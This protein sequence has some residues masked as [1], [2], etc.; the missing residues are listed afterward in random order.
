M[1]DRRTQL[2]EFQK[3]FLEAAD[4]HPQVE[5]AVCLFRFDLGPDWEGFLNSRLYPGC[6][7]AFYS[8]ARATDNKTGF[9]EV[10]A[11]C[12][13]GAPEALAEYRQLAEGLARIIPPNHFPSET[14]HKFVTARPAFDRR[15][16]Q[17]LIRWLYHHLPHLHCQEDWGGHPA[18]ML[19]TGLFRA[20]AEAIDRYLLAEDIPRGVES[21]IGGDTKNVVENADVLTATSDEP[22]SVTPAT[23]ESA[24]NQPQP[25]N[26]PT[27]RGDKRSR[28]SP[29]NWAVAD[30]G[31][32]WNLYHLS[33]GQW[34]RGRKLDIP[35]GTLTELL[36]M[37]AAQDGSLNGAT[38]CKSLFEHFWRTGEWRKAHGHLKTACCRLGKIIREAIG[39]DKKTVVVSYRGKAVQTIFP[40]AYARQSEEKTS[41]MDRP[42]QLVNH[43]GVTVEERI[44][45]EEST[46]AG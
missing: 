32:S 5:H 42:W 24:T 7:K 45:I 33:R 4:R 44:D 36:K 34:Q 37:L 19:R 40:I 21:A 43:A 25:P 23:K 46:T 13:I 22:V 6:G 31:R 20:P 41:G 17:N 14:I 38:A 11:L 29:K 1:A 9:P 8:L 2:T 28:I 12:L 10:E 26:T 3:L 27:D 35:N 18:L 16:V 39:L 15:P 30:D